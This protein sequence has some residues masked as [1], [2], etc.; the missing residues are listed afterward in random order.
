MEN[1]EGE[2]NLRCWATA[3]EKKKKKGVT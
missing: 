2:A 1:P 3:M